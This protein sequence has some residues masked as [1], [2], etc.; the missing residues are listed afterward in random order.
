MFNR[1]LQLPQQE[2]QVHKTHKPTVFP[3]RTHNLYLCIYIHHIISFIK[4]KSSTRYNINNTRDTTIHTP[5]TP[6]P[7]Q[8][9]TQQDNVTGIWKTLFPR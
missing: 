9:K 5:L 3:T 7:H 1:T 4:T 2:K 6:W 8:A